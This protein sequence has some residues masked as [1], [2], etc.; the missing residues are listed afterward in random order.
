MKESCGCST[1]YEKLAN[2]NILFI[3]FVCGLSH[4]VHAMLHPIALH[5]GNTC[6]NF[7]VVYNSYV[8]QDTHI[9]YLAQYFSDLGT[10]RTQ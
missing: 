2:K 4:V 6:S 7:F 1:T 10:L 3:S 9:V 5:Q 8:F